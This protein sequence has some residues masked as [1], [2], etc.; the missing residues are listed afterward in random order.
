M[1]EMHWNSCMMWRQ[2]IG[3]MIKNGEKE[4]FYEGD[5]LLWLLKPIRYLKR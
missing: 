1:C 2:H 3:N 5:F 4:F